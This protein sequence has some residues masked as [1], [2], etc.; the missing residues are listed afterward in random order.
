MASIT[1]VSPHLDYCVFCSFLGSDLS[2]TDKNTR[3]SEMLQPCSRQL[4]EDTKTNN[5][6][7]KNVRKITS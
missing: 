7:S 1:D 2:S 3:R 6:A 5:G 4:Y